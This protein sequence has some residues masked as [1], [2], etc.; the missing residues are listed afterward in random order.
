MLE[1]PS[2]RL[3]GEGA[4]ER[5]MRGPH[6]ALRATLSRK[7]ERDTHTLRIASFRISRCVK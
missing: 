1:S 6:P 4:A 7:R 3:R 5:R 2:P